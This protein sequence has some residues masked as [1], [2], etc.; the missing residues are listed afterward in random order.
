MGTIL[1]FYFQVFSAAFY[2]PRHYLH[3][4]VTRK[5]SLLF[6]DNYGTRKT[7]KV[8]QWLLRHPRF[9]CHFTLTYSSW[10]NLVKR[11]L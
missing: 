4:Q 10:I 5:K 7:D 1:P 11:F 9:H 3:F 2:P 8:R 6:E